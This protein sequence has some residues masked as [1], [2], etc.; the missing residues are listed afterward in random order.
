[1]LVDHVIP[2]CGYVVDIDRLGFLHRDLARAIRRHERAPRLNASF[3]TSVPGLHF[4][5]PASAARF[6]P[7]FR[8][9]AGAEYTARTLAAYL[10]S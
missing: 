6:G 2:G 4:A 9:V 5:G 1:M 10:A 8:F 3:Q 7:L